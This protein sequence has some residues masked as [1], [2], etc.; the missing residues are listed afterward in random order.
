MEGR[1]SKGR[2]QRFDATRDFCPECSHD[3][4]CP[5]GSLAEAVHDCGSDEMKALSD[6]FRRER[7][8]EESSFRGMLVGVFDSLA[9]GV[10]L[11]YRRI[12]SKEVPD[13]AIN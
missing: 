10:T 13:A 5:A 3:L 11:V 12:K 7:I 1:D 8:R 4:T 9:W 2:I 6:V